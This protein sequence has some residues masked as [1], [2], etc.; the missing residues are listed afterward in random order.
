[1]RTV[2]KFCRCGFHA[3]L[4]LFTD[5]S[6]HYICCLGHIDQIAQTKLVEHS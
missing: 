5:E 3:H 2:E 6:K 1:M 4:S